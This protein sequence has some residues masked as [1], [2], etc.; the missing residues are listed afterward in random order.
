MERTL[1]C[2]AKSLAELWKLQRRSIRYVH[3]APKMYAEWYW[4]M[5]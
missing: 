2:L 4:V 3:W 1:R 5:N